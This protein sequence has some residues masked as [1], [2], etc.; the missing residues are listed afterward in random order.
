MSVIGSQTITADGVTA[1]IDILIDEHAI[2]AYL[3]PRAMRNRTG[4]ATISKAIETGRASL[5]IAEVRK[6]SRSQS[7]SDGSA[8]R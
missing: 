1:T 8:K 3:G 4:R 6:A 7:S 5:L 2:L